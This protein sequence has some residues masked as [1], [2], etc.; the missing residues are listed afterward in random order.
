VAIRVVG[1]AVSISFLFLQAPDLAV[2]SVPLRDLALIILVGPSSEDHHVMESARPAA[3]LGFTLIGLAAVFLLS[4]RSF[5]S[6]PPSGSLCSRPPVLP[7]E[8]RRRYG[9][10]QHRRRHILATAYDTLGEVHG[11]A[12]A[13]LGR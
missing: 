9:R 1:L 2:V 10:G 3:D 13:I 11:P 5:A 6:F 4:L 7:A 12:D 8:R